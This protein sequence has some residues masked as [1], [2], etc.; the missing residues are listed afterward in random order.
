LKAIARCD[1]IEAAEL[2]I[3][4]LEHGGPGEREAAIGALKV[5]R[6]TRFVDVA[7]AAYPQASEPLKRAI[8]EILRGRGLQV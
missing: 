2:L 3:G 4:A 6:G 7:R 5:A 1:V 8:G